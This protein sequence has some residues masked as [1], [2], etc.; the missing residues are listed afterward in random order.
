VTPQELAPIA[1]QSQ[2]RSPFVFVGAV[3]G[4]V[5]LGAILG[6]V[7]RAAGV[8]EKVT[9]AFPLALGLPAL[10]FAF[11]YSSSAQGWVRV[12]A[13]AV[14]VEPRLRSARVWNR[15]TS[16]PTLRAWQLRTDG[17]TRTAGPLL[18]FQGRDGTFTLGSLD[19]AVGQRLPG[20]EGLTLLVP[21]DFVVARDDFATLAAELGISLPR[22]DPSTSE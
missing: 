7:G 21:P 13:T 5:V 3:V 2:G 10:L 17:V 15:G 4:A 8:P 14:T 22:P 19:P 12:D 20:P 9:Y 6:G 18:E 1:L 11:W 16:A